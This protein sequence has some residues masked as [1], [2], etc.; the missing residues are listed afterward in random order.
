MQIWGTVS[1]AYCGFNRDIKG[2][3]RSEVRAADEILAVLLK[4]TAHAGA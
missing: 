3:Q 2:G 4:D 1:V